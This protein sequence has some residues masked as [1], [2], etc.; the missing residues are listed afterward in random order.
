MQVINFK[1][2]VS[3]LAQKVGQAEAKKILMRSVYLFSMGGNDY[4]SFNTDHA[5]ANQFERKVFM[6]MVIGNITNG[7]KVR[8]IFLINEMQK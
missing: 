1:K 8:L 6:H 2:V 3:S 7:L 4:F 5:N